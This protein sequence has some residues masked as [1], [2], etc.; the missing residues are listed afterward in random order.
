MA[1]AVGGTIGNFK[2]RLGK[3]SARVVNGETILSARS[4]S[5]KESKNPKHIEVKQKFAVTSTFT[6][7]VL[8]LPALFRI[9]KLNKTPKLSE[10]N[11]VFKCNYAFSSI[12]APTM[13]NIITPQGFT[14]PITSAVIN[15]GKLTVALSALNSIIIVNNDEINISINAVICNYDP[16][17]ENDPYF[18][19]TPVSKEILDFNF[20]EPCN[21]E[22]KLNIESAAIVGKYKKKIIFLAVA[23]KSAYNEIVRYSQS[24]SLSSD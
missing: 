12:K 16:L 4:A 18:E 22:M 11:E 19:I 14:S 24:L 9:W 2:G 6:K 15:E 20:S 8:E 3:V 23:T 13:Q 17:E 10:F 1:R 7:G 5:F 21:L